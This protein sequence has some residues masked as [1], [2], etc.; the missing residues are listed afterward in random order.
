MKDVMNDTGNDVTDY[1]QP[2]T[3]QIGAGKPRFFDGAFI[4]VAAILI[5]AAVSLNATVQK[6]QLSFR[7]EPV[8]LQQSLKELSPVL[9]PWVL[10]TTDERASYELEDALGTKEY[11][12]RDYID[13]RLVSAD[14]IEQFKG[15]PAAERHQM[16]GVIRGKTPQAV[17]H[18][19]VTYYTGMVDTVAHIPDRCYVADGFVPSQYDISRWECFAERSSDNQAA[20]R[21]IHFVDQVAERQSIPR[22]VA[23]FFNVN[24]RYTN[25]PLDVRATLQDLFQKHGYYAKV[26]M[27]SALEDRKLAEHAMAD[28]AGHALPELEKVLPDWEKVK[29]SELASAGK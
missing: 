28:F 2:G 24:G 19:G 7:K 16:L 6:M 3:A 1:K 23:Y 13:S 4:A 9:G 5:I 26:E 21:F 12:F 20:A 15:K 25:D 8:A 29:A 22:N 10:V 27:M 14:V 11:I 18:V 17:I